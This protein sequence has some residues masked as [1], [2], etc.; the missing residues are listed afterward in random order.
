MN[1]IS[2]QKK[3]KK[4]KK[5]WKAMIFFPGI[6]ANDIHVTM[7]MIIPISRIRLL[8]STR[9]LSDLVF[10]FPPPLI[11]VFFFALFPNFHQEIIMRKMMKPSS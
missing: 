1:R 5:N 6:D 2:F 8:H 4:K 11:F 9:I 10:D 7:I 3:K